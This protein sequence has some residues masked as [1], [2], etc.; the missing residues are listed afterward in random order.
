MAEEFRDEPTNRP[1]PIT[2]NTKTATDNLFGIFKEYA[3]KKKKLSKNDIQK[4]T[5]D[6]FTHSN[7]HV[8]DK[9]AIKRV[10]P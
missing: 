7:D 9:F 2:E 3:S 6:G 1:S 5:N 10:E 8:F 4:A